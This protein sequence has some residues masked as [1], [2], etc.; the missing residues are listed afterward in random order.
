MHHYVGEL[1]YKGPRIRFWQIS[2]LH[3]K[4]LYS[5]ILRGLEGAFSAAES[6]LL[7]AG[8]RDSARLLAHMFIKWASADGA[9]GAFA[10]HG[11][12]P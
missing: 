3:M 12:I 4:K 8:K 9:Q 7:A 2:F 11:T 5:S 6:H 1:L 10:L